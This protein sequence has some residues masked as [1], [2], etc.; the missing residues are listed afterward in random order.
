[1]CGVI[2]R[3]S[4]LEIRTD[5]ENRQFK[6]GWLFALLLV[7]FNLLH[8]KYARVQFIITNKNFFKT[9]YNSFIFSKKR[10]TLIV[11]RILCKKVVK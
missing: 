10:N 8:I 4:I 6:N 2:I 5:S 3:N 7:R 9:F 1:M 11:V